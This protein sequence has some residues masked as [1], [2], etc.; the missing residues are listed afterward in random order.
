MGGG[1]NP[2]KISF[3]EPCDCFIPLMDPHD[4]DF[5]E[6]LWWLRFPFPVGTPIEM[7]RKSFHI[8]VRIKGLWCENSHLLEYFIIRFR[9]QIL[10]I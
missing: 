3:Q 6:H 2:S 10:Q 9:F 8:E 7:V 1:K 5:V 4:I